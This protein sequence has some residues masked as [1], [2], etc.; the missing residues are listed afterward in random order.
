MERRDFLKMTAGAGALSLSSAC[1]S[2][3]DAPH[4]PAAAAG[5]TAEQLDEAAA[6]PVL[7]VEGITSPVI[8]D[9]IRL[10]RKDREYFIHVRSKDGA[11]GISLDNGR[12]EDF[13]PILNQSIIPFFIGKDARDL[14]T[15]LW[16]LYR[17]QSNYKLQGLAFWSAHAWV[18]F[19]ILDMLGRIANKSIGQLFGDIVRQEV[20]FYVASGRRDTTPPEEIEYLQSLIEETGAKAVKFRLGGRMSRN[21]DA[22]PDRTTTLV[23]LTRKTFGDSIALHGDANSSYDSEHGIAIGR[24]LEENK[25]LHYEEPCP[26]DDLEATKKVADA[27]TIQVAGGEQEFSQYRFRWMI[28]NRA[29][30][31]VQPDLHYYGGLIRSKRVANMAALANMPTTVHLSG[32]FAF[33]YTLHFAASVPDVGP[34]QEYK[35]GIERYADWF[36]PHLEIK[37]GALIIPQGPGVGIKDI[38][39][40]IQGA[41]EPFKMT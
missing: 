10:L 9:S 12:A 7:N 28:E 24:L 6:R 5:P 22:L 11:E 1:S 3:T 13:H 2:Q 17:H 36:D 8:I 34:Y 33:V 21:A 15:H 38:G 32:G 23:P 25:F 35:R 14:E 18:E 29:V 27:L 16:E 26:F 4:A 37:D 19:A 30:D 40:V 39:S 20:P 41:A 31:I